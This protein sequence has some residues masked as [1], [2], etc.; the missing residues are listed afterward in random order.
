MKQHIDYDG[1]AD[2]GRVPKNTEKKIS[3]ASIWGGLA[4]LLGFILFILALTL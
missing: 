2:Q 4:I 1:M 3:R